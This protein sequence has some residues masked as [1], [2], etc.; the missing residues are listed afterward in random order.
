MQDLEQS[1]TRK[2]AVHFLQASPENPFYSGV[3]GNMKREGRIQ[4]HP[5]E[6][7]RY[8]MDHMGDTDPLAKTYTFVS[9]NQKGLAPE[10]EASPQ[11]GAKVTLYSQLQSEIRSDA[12]RRS[13][14]DPYAIH[15]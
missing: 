2:Q 9:H 6:D 14:L 11:S 15:K 5:G 12:Q 10:L 7:P 3:G 13:N 4:R 8:Q 1:P